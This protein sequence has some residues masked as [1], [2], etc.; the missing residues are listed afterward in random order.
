MTPFFYDFEPHKRNEKQGRFVETN[1]CD[2]SMA[3]Q[4]STSFF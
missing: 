4:L 2:N 1:L 3:V